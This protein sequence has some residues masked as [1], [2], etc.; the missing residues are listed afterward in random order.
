MLALWPGSALHYL[1]AIRDPR[2]EDWTFKTEDGANRFSYLGNGHSF[3]EANQEDLSYYIR[4]H[5]DSPIDP[6][7][8]KPTKE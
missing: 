3:V 4:D 7:L 5:D 8:K 1:E 2:W 6:V